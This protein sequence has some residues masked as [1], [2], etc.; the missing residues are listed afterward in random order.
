MSAVTELL[1]LTH[2]TAEVT[3][4]T[5]MHVGDQDE[6]AYLAETLLATDFADP[7]HALL[8]QAM[9]NCLRGPEPMDDRAILTESMRIAKATGQKK[10]LAQQYL[11]TF[12]GEHQR[13]KAYAETLKRLAHLRVAGDYAYWYIH[14][15]EE[16]PDPEEFYNEAQE[17]LRLLQPPV[18]DGRF[19]Y[20]WDTVETHQAEVTQRRID[21]LN[22]KVNP[23]LWPWS[24]WNKVFRPLRPGMVG[25]I[26]AAEGVGKSTFLELI[27]EFWAST[28]LHVVVVHLEDSLDYKLDRRLARWANVP[29]DHIE[30]GTLTPEE[31]TRVED[32]QLCI[33]ERLRT[34]HYFNAAGM[35]MAEI[36][37]ELTRR[38][39]EGVCQCVILDYLNKVQ[40]SRA[41]VKLFGDQQYA[42]QENDV[43]LLKTAA[44]RLQVPI[45]TAAQ[46]NKNYQEQ[47][48]KARRKDLTGSL[49][50]SQK[51][52]FVVL[53]YREEIGPEGLYD[54]DDV[55]LGGPGELSPIVT[56]RADKQNRGK[57][58]ATVTQFFDGPHF[59]VKDIEFRR[60]TLEY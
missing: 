50:I 52:Q 3:V 51:A 33:D 22:G 7:H 46:G 32:A 12:K 53:L 38:V 30:D 59:N 41:Q 49:A 36:V 44:E 28:G 11:D 1:E 17:R 42:R 56:V 9:A 40:P 21:T 20:G 45:M 8:F 48:A 31:L 35:S 60:V 24:S 57:A 5:A 29:L 4:L 25:V 27:S 23:F 6:A 26:G 15:L 10:G 39:S 37:A 14:K 47:G 16:R 54:D 58:G 13:A 43:E 19:V 34:L 55:L 2:P 18:Q